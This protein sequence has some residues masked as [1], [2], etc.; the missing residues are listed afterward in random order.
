MYSRCRGCC[1]CSQ[2]SASLKST[3]STPQFSPHSAVAPS[4]H[5]GAEARELAHR[6]HVAPQMQPQHHHRTTRRIC[7]AS[8]RSKTRRMQAPSSFAS[9]IA[10][11]GPSPPPRLPACVPVG[12]SNGSE[13]H[14]MHRASE[15]N[16]WEGGGGSYMQVP[17]RRCKI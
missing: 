1:C 5:S 17:V 16:C 15:K 9:R 6:C 3:A 4:A 7:E 10:Q 12:H 2:L 8:K 13:W 14:H 11:S